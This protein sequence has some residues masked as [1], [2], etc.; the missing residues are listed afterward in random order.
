M[1]AFGEWEGN[2]SRWLRCVGAVLINVGAVLINVGAV[3]INVGAVLIDVGAVLIDVGAASAAM[4]YGYTA[5]LAFR[6]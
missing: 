6:R 3:L 4:P 5:P 1:E 2:P